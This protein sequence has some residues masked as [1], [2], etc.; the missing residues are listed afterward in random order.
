MGLD[1][2]F[3]IG[4]LFLLLGLLLT[5][6]GAATDGNADLYRSSLGLNVNLAWGIVLFLFG[7][8]MFALAWFGRSKRP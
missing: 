6:Y 5:G 3:P 7:A 8:V 2:R 4:M 1:L